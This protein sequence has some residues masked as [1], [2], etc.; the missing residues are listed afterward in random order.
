MIKAV[1][2]TNILVSALLWEG[3]PNQLLSLVKEGKIEISLSI[4]MIVE[5]EEVLHREKFK[6]RIKELN[7]NVGELLSGLLILADIYELENVID[8]IQED[9]DDNMF[10]E[11]A[12]YSGAD[13]IISGD[14]H[15]LDLGKYS[16]I[17]IMSPKDFFT[18]VMNE[19][20]E[21]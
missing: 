10:L 5:L 6:N 21:E 7:T 8:V 13:Y 9:P 3:L 1:F 18:N 4:K 14:K 17:V 11:C 16:G 2:D 20:S 12:V 19:T 15:L